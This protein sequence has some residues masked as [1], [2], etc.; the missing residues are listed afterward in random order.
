MTSEVEDVPPP[1]WVDDSWRGDVTV[2]VEAWVGAAHGDGGDSEP[3]PK[4]L[5]PDADPEAV[6]RKI[7]LDQLTGQARTRFELRAKLAQKNV[8]EEIAERLLDR[9]EEVGLIDDAAFAR[10]WV[11]SRSRARGLAPRALADELRRKGVDREAAQAALELVDPVAQR[12]RARELVDKKLRSLRDVDDVTAT[13]RLVG[14][15]ARKGY[16]SSLAF[17]VVR[18]AL[19]QQP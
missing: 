7:L 11:E 10:A 6:A 8:P 1:P 14:L 17:A 13:R 3:D 4:S 9:F 16:A 12:V 19:E 18:E 5:G 2:G 15:L